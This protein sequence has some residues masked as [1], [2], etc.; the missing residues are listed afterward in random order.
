MSY[1]NRD[2]TKEDIFCHYTS[3]KP[4]AINLRKAKKR[5]NLMDKEKVVF[6]IV[7]SKSKSDE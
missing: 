1:L 3:I 2:D 4:M 6:D 5:L 7:K